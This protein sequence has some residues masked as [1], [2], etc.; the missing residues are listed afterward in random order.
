MATSAAS[1]A[2]QRSSGS[3]APVSNMSSDVPL[4]VTEPESRIVCDNVILDDTHVL[5]TVS[6]RNTASVPVRVELASNLGE[7]LHFQLENENLL[8]SGE[9]KQ[10]QEQ[11]QVFNY[12]NWIDAVELAPGE[13]RPVIITYLPDETHYAASSSS[14]KTGGTDD[15]QGHLAENHGFFEIH[16]KIF[17]NA[18]ALAPVGTADEAEPLRFQ[19]TLKFR[20]HVCRSIMAVDASELDLCF[21]DCVVDQNCFM[22]FSVHNKSQIPLT[23]AISNLAALA[24]Q[25]LDFSHVDTGETISGMVVVSGYASIQLRANYRPQ[26][27][28]DFC[29]V[30]QLFNTCNAGNRI[31]VHLWAVVSSQQQTEFLQ[32]DD[33]LDFG[34]CFTN[35]VYDTQLRIRNVSEIP[36]ELNFTAPPS[37]P[38]TFHMFVRERTISDSGVTSRPENMLGELNLT[39]GKQR[40]IL[41]RFKPGRID[42]AQRA[43]QLQRRPFFIKIT[44]HNAEGDC[45]ER[46]SVLCRARVCESRIEASATEIDFGELTVGKLC[47]KTIDISNLSDLPATVV[48]TIRSKTV[49]C[50][51]RS[52]F[53]IPP[54]QSRTVRLSLTPTSA[55]PDFSTLVAFRNKFT[56]LNAQHIT[57][58]AAIIDEHAHAEHSGL[59]SL[60]VTGSSNSEL[61]FGDAIVESL[62]LR[63]F[64]IKSQSSVPL[65]LTVT[66][67]RPDI[68]LYVEGSQ[69]QQHGRAH[70]RPGAPRLVSQNFVGRG[71]PPSSTVRSQGAATPRSRAARRAHRAEAHVLFSE[72][73]SVGEAASVDDDAV[74]SSMSSEVSGVHGAPG[75]VSGLSGAAGIAIS[76]STTS[77]PRPRLPAQS[78]AGAGAA[79]DDGEANVGTPA[80][81]GRHHSSTSAMLGGGPADLLH[82]ANQ[83]VLVEAAKK[84][85][86]QSA[87]S[88]A[89]GPVSGIDYLD[90]ASTQKTLSRAALVV[91]QSLTRPSSPADRNAF[92]QRGLGDEWLSTHRDARRSI[93]ATS[94]S[95]SSVSEALAMQPASGKPGSE[96]NEI[97][98]KALVGE[99]LSTSGS[100]HFASVE[101]EEIYIRTQSRLHDTLRAARDSGQLRTLHSQPVLPGYGKLVVYVIF[102]PTVESVAHALD[103]DNEGAKVK[104]DS[105]SISISHGPSTPRKIPVLATVCRSILHIEQRH[106]NFG[107]MT[108]N[109]LRAKSLFI[110]NASEAPLLYK[111]K[112][113]G[114]I[115]SGHLHI[116]DGRTGVVAPY[117]TREVKFMF[118]PSFAGKFEEQLFVNNMIDQK[119]HEVILL[120]A[121]VK[122]LPRFDVAPEIL[123]FPQSFLGATKEPLMLVLSNTSSHA[124]CFVVRHDTNAC[125]FPGIA[126]MLHF[127]CDATES[128]LLSQ[129]TEERIVHYEQKLRIAERKKQT[130]K[131]QRIRVKLDKLRTGAVDAIPMSASEMSG[132]SDDERQRQDTNP[133]SRSGDD[134]IRVVVRPGRSRQV[135]VFLISRSLVADSPP[136]AAAAK[137]QQGSARPRLEAITGQTAIVVHEK[138]NKDIIKRTTVHGKIKPRSLTTSGSGFNA[139][140]FGQRPVRS[141]SPRQLGSSTAALAALSPEKMKTARRASAGGRQQMPPLSPRFPRALSLDADGANSLDAPVARSMLDFDA[142]EQLDLN[143]FQLDPDTIDLGTVELRQTRRAKFAVVNN[144]PRE[145]RFVILIKNPADA[146]PLS[147]TQNISTAF[148]VPRGGRHMQ[149]LV[150]SPVVTGSQKLTLGVLNIDTRTEKTLILKALVPQPAY[151]AFPDFPEGSPVLKFGICYMTEAKFLRILPLHVKSMWDQ[152]LVLQLQSNLAQQVLFFL[153]ASGEVQST[154]VNLA[155]HAEE[156]I[157][158]GLSPHLPENAAVGNSR[159]IE[160]GIH[161]QVHKQHDLDNE[162]AR[163]TVK[164]DAIAGQSAFKRTKRLVKLGTSTELGKVFH[165]DFGLRNM[166]TLLPVNYRILAPDGIELEKTEGEIAPRKTETINFRVQATQYGLQ[167]YRILVSNPDSEQ[168]PVE[169]NVML[170]VDVGAVRCSGTIDSFDGDDLPK[171]QFPKVHVKTVRGGLPHFTLSEPM[172]ATAARALPHAMSFELENTTDSELLLAPCSDLKLE[173]FVLHPGENAVDKLRYRRETALAMTRDRLEGCLSPSHFANATPR[174]SLRSSRSAFLSPDQQDHH[175]STS[176]PQQLSPSSP[177]NAPPGMVTPSQPLPIGTAANDSLLSPGMPGEASLVYDFRAESCGDYIQL[178]AHSKATVIVTCPQPVALGHR[179][180]QKLNDGSTIQYFGLIQLQRVGLGGSRAPSFRIPAPAVVSEPDIVKM[181]DVAVSFCQSRGRLVNPV[182]DVGNVGYLSSWQPRPFEFEVENKSD[183][184]LLI[185]FAHASMRVSIHAVRPSVRPLANQVRNSGSTASGGIRSTS[186]AHLLDSPPRSPRQPL[187]PTAQ[188]GSRNSSDGSRNGED[189]DT[190]LPA[191]ALQTYSEMIQPITMNPEDESGG[192]V[193]VPQEIQF[194][195]ASQLLCQQEEGSTTPPCVSVSGIRVFWNLKAGGMRHPAVLLQAGA[196]AVFRGVV[197]P[198]GLNDPPGKWNFE[199]P[200]DNLYNPLES[201]SLQLEGFFSKHALLFSNLAGDRNDLVIPPLRYPDV[202]SQLSSDGWF[203]IE[204]KGEGL[205]EYTRFVVKTAVAEKFANILCI[206]LLARSAPNAVE[207]LTLADGEAR[208]L[209]VRI[210]FKPDTERLNSETLHTLFPAEDMQL[211]GQ[212]LFF[213]HDSRTKEQ[214]PA[215]SLDVRGTI[216]EA[217]ILAVNTNQVWLYGKIDDSDGEASD[218]DPDDDNIAPDEQYGISSPIPENQRSEFTVTC[219]SELFPL[220]Y[221]IICEKVEMASG[222][223]A[224]IPQL[225]DLIS[226]SP[227]RGLIQPRSEQTVQLQLIQNVLEGRVTV[228][229]LVRDIHGATSN[230]QRVIVAIVPE[231][232]TRSRQWKSATGA[233]GNSLSHHNSDSL[234]LA[235]HHSSSI[236]LLGCA[237]VDVRSNVAKSNYTLNVGQCDKGATVTKLLTLKNYSKD[238]VAF[239]ILL[240]DSANSWLKIEPSNGEI[241][242][243]SKSTVSRDAG[244]GQPGSD[245]RESAK[246]GT[247]RIEISICAAKPGDFSTYFMIQLASGE[248]ETKFVRI[249]TQSVLPMMRDSR[250]LFRIRIPTVLEEAMAEELMDMGRLFYGNTYTHYSFVVIN[251]SNFA[252]PFTLGSNV[253]VGGALELSFARTAGRPAVTCRNFTLGPGERI[254]VYLHLTCRPLLRKSSSSASLLLEGQSMLRNSLHAGVFAFGSTSGGSGMRSLL[255]GGSISPGLSSLDE[256]LTGGPA[257]SPST[258][259]FSS[260]SSSQVTTPRLAQDDRGDPLMVRTPSGSKPVTITVTCRS[261]RSF[262]KT[263]KVVGRVVPASLTV[264][265]QELAFV[266]DRKRLSDISTGQIAAPALITVQASNGEPCALLEDLSY[267]DVSR[268]PCMVHGDDAICQAQSLANCPVTLAVTPRWSVIESDLHKLRTLALQERLCILNLADPREIHTVLL[269]V[270]RSEGGVVAPVYSP[271]QYSYATLEVRVSHLVKTLMSQPNDISSAELLCEYVYVVDQLIRRVLYNREQFSRT[272][273]G[274]LA[275]MLFS[276]IRRLPQFVECAPAFLSSHV[277]R[278]RSAYR[279]AEDPFANPN[280]QLW[281]P[282]LESWIE[283]MLCFAS[284]DSETPG[285]HELIRSIVQVPK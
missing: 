20:S 283:P 121:N 37:V 140:S 211:M 55:D 67:S 111:I 18:T 19:K 284:L 65:N 256:E 155:P 243:A 7:Q 225:E 4:I 246:P 49:K 184:T 255:A 163:V 237:L 106:I 22:D 213:A 91:K 56:P 174:S 104:I 200:I 113:T 215:E 224:S 39:P 63:S 244:A 43:L 180:A 217:S 26:T 160:G 134:E 282:E 86:V 196:S 31:Q 87:A 99:Y 154:T 208:D 48:P 204:R 80:A 50:E 101:D 182:V 57:I 259:S 64:S 285:L 183:T 223:D 202:E 105:A 221:E 254:T 227:Q 164:L 9:L 165:G 198:T 118:K 257:P 44:S 28:G 126:V 167:R 253:P 158:V 271:T 258:I 269:S 250:D 181:F 125:D 156:I 175:S 176:P 268:V 171:L 137:R 186:P 187:S 238:P 127:E 264:E 16:G 192:A 27:V 138:H 120:K 203:T 245:A 84:Q 172:L 71:S 185:G 280:V 119:N 232:P 276:S 241:P 263:I 70:R 21:Q 115:A 193:F 45:V 25:N 102:K 107:V 29:F 249:T 17:I 190:T 189:G 197:D 139:I 170:F 79:V 169:V 270:R 47:H 98:L 15:L 222:A 228:T 10:P 240:L 145:A 76:S 82:A 229:L 85:A 239:D 151:L 272:F 242:A 147:G 218:V 157:Y 2:V 129:S 72:E 81:R 210:S 73:V 33:Q 166:T 34:D 133:T 95:E 59:Y 69:A 88:E 110:K 5:R 38:V 51:P 1:D 68:R 173:M 132:V 194:D 62:V 230:D 247:Q 234:D 114:S 159:K 153:D 142:T 219:L 14:K 260:D 199:V 58:R 53:E 273:A 89:A 161:I 152:P 144:M 66:S 3:S 93:S 191:K 178:A 135:K 128:V 143:V 179:K 40:I 83:P 206:E 6:I 188:H 261:V 130:D 13:A 46:R 94:G 275:V 42:D 8:P 90:L 32:T 112:K 281:P 233:G 96:G 60:S 207:E 108:K 274:D 24:E 177:Y 205:E 146:S 277:E 168:A 109:E 136:S 231:N 124:L 265:P 148:S 251:R 279:L 35:T 77:R 216:K 267:F 92:K 141:P 36:L 74:P 236:E 78:N 75:V 162:L 97:D 30:V 52:E 131:V 122:Q 41:V 278:L 103:K 123:K 262:H 195:A 252:L 214:L 61:D 149:T 201:L 266:L 220:E 150:F 209:R 12:V 23:F 226:I 117:A 235:G 212:I 116:N 100:Q 11:N 54:H 248:L